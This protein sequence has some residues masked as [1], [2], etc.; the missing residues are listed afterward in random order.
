MFKLPSQATEKLEEIYE[1]PGGL[2]D[3]GGMIFF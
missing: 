3:Y 2:G 1:S